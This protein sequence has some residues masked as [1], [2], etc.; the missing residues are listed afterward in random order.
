MN[1]NPSHC[2]LSSFDSTFWVFP[3]NLR[4]RPAAWVS[5]ADASVGK[6]AETAVWHDRGHLS[7]YTWGKNNCVCDKSWSCECFQ[8]HQNQMGKQQ[9]GH[10]CAA[11]NLAGCSCWS[12]QDQRGANSWGALQIFQTQVLPTKV[13]SPA[14]LLVFFFCRVEVG[15]TW[16]LWINHRWIMTDMATMMCA[17]GLRWMDRHQTCLRDLVRHF[18]IA[19]GY[20]T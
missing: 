1:E 16:Y 19:E 15:G 18:Q 14:R 12:I 10:W 13:M 4:Q 2:L 8:L 9:R 11:K 17:A 7:R 6:T 20:S 5:L 3:S